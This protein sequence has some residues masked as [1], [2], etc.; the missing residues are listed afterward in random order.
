MGKRPE[1]WFKQAVYDMKTGEIMFDNGRY[2]Y[3]V[4]MCHLSL[5][6]A[7]KGLYGQR[8]KK[9]PPKIHNLIYL[10][11]RINVNL[12]KGL[13]DFV[14]TLNR[15]SIPTRYPDDLQRILK[16]YDKKKTE[17]ILKKGKEVLKCLKAK[18]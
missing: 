13:Y 5:E 12:P 11:E 14:F 2:I 8:L 17:E 7:L 16:D 6:K 9:V 15:A 4:F 18:L 10:I 3:A 1:E